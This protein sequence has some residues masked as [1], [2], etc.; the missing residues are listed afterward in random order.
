M[1]FVIFNKFINILKENIFFKWH[2]RLIFF[3][4]ANHLAPVQLVKPT[5]ECNPYCQQKAFLSQQ[6]LTRPW[7]RKTFFVCVSWY[8][9][10]KQT[11]RQVIWSQLRHPPPHYSLTLNWSKMWMLK[12]YKY[13]HKEK[14]KELCIL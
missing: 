8:N 10:C 6:L 7:R 14:K 12:L 1:M 3:K 9:S 4:V 11:E 13:E 5:T 2:F